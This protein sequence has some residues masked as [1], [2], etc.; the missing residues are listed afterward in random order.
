MWKLWAFK[1]FN[2]AQTFS[3]HFKYLI[4]FQ[5]FFNCL[6]FSHQYYH[7]ICVSA[8]MQLY[9]Q[10]NVLLKIIASY[11]LVCPLF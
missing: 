7:T 11:P 10:G 4:S 6:I 2:M 9:T 1:E 8:D 3:R 5:N